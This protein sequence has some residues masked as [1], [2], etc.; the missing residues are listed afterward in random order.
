[1]ILPVGPET[2]LPPRLFDKVKDRM[3]LKP[4]MKLDK[5]QFSTPDNPKCPKT[6]FIV[7]SIMKFRFATRK[8]MED[9]KMVYD[10]DG[11]PKMQGGKPAPKEEEE[12]DDDMGGDED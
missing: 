4:A 8:E 3:A 1:M 5:D 12:D 2:Y 11:D 10:R 6:S 7:G 9:S